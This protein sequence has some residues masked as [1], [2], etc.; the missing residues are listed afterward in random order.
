MSEAIQ[1]PKCG[2]TQIHA[3][4]RGWSIWTG[5]FGARKIVLTCLKCG[6]TFKPG[7]GASEHHSAHHGEPAYAPAEPIRQVDNRI[8]KAVDLTCVIAVV[9]VLGVAASGLW[10]RSDDAHES[11]VSQTAQ[12]EQS[13]QSD[14]AEMAEQDDQL[15]Q[16]GRVE[17]AKAQAMS[18]ALA[19]HP[20][21]TPEGREAQDWVQQHPE[22]VQEA[23]QSAAQADAAPAE[24]TRDPDALAV[25]QDK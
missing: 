9:V 3:A 21:D 17:V 12:A 24:A 13:S 23:R 8:N 19:G 25:Q 14:Q 5:F 20:L 10:T 2:S 4:Q 11:S 7:Q 1:C 15:E 22:E 6:N 18:A 16:A